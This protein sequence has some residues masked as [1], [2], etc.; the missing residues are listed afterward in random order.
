M[1]R[2]ERTKRTLSKDNPQIV[3]NRQGITVILITHD[4]SVAVRAH[5]LIRVLDG[6]IREDRQL[7]CAG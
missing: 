6:R 4:L 7:A 1:K 5:R 2:S 3:I